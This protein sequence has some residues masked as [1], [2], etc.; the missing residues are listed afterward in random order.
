VNR[1]EASREALRH[2][3][4]VPRIAEP[5]VVGE[6]GVEL[7]GDEAHLRQAMAAAVLAERELFGQRLVEHDDRLGGERAVLRGAE[8]QEV[9]AGAPGEVGGRRAGRCDGVGEAGAVEVYPQAAR[10]IP[11]GTHFIG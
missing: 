2:G 9:D 8:G 3:V 4:C 10:N 6:V 5:E 1:R 11:Q 7:R